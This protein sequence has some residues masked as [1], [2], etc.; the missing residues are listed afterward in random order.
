VSPAKYVIFNA[1]DF[2]ASRGINRAIVDCH[3]NGVV[4]STS[5]MVT[6][7][8]IAEA[9]AL[10][11]DHPELAV[12][13]HFDVLGEEDEPKYDLGN[14]AAVRDEFRRQLDEFR[15]LFGRAPTHVDS[16]RHAHM[17]PH[18]FPVFKE[19]VAPLG[20][21]LRG[22]GRVKFTGGF[23]AQWEWKV[24]DLAHVSVAALQGILK[25]EMAEG[26]NEVS[27]HPGYVTPDFRSIY[28]AERAEE[29]KT[30]TDPAIKRCLAELGY[31][32]ASYAACP[33]S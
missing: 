1:D 7:A 5:A 24:T 27:C 32:L 19:M 28:L 26:W 21:P 29:A 6:G 17:K 25:N 13:L 14:V 20:V 2:G 9:V 11:R 22:D 8:A 12:G 23:Y 10:S 15:R 30:L 18:L 3:V 31:R 33:Q 4:T 16:H